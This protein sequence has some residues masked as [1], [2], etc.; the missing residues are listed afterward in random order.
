MCARMIIL[1]RFLLKESVRNKIEARTIITKFSFRL[2]FLLKLY[3]KMKKGIL[4][5]RNYRLLKIFDRK[6]RFIFSLF[7]VYFSVVS[8]WCWF[9][10]YHFRAI[11]C[12]QTLPYISF[13]SF[14]KVLLNSELTKI[15]QE[16]FQLIIGPRNSSISKYTAYFIT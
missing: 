13:K 16:Y 11:N 14:H 15:E 2:I 10:V 5:E 1:S 9:F 6:C 12:P 4:N 8:K 3:A 7:M